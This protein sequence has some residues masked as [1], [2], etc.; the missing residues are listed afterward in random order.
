MKIHI[1]SCHGP[2]SSDNTKQLKTNET[3]QKIQYVS[4]RIRC[5]QCEKKFNKRETYEIH[6]RKFHKDIILSG[7]NDFTNNIQNMK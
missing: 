7:E 1:E 2:K 6:V 3:K 5:E 4:K